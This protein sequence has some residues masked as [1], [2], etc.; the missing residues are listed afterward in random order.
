LV[1]FLVGV[2]LAAGFLAVV[3]YGPLRGT[4]IQ[5]YLIHP[6]ECAELIMFGIA[7][8]ALGA[9]LAGSWAER[10]ASRTAVLPTW[11]GRAVP[12]SEASK[13]L[14]GLAQLPRRLQNTWMVKRA[15]A[16]LEFLCSRGSANELDD[17]LRTLADNDAT[18]LES[19]YSLIRLIT[20]AVPILGFLGTVLG[21]TTAISGVT[22]E[23]LENNISNVT[24]GLSEA[25]D[26]TA[27]A[28]GLTMVAMFI[29]FVVERVEQGIL[30]AVDRFADR[31]LAHRFERSG[32]E[33]GEFVEVVRRNSDVLVGAMEQLVQ[34][35]TTLWSAALEAAEKRRL[36]VEQRQ[37][38]R[39]TAGLEVALK[40]T[41]DAHAQRLAAWE[42]Q[43]ADQGGKLL[44]Q[45]TALAGAVRDMGHEQQ[46]TLGQISQG[47]A[48]QME[49]LGELQNGEKHLRRLQDTLNQN[50][51]ALAG[52]GTFEQAL[53]SLTAAIHLL[54]A[55]A[56]A[57]PATTSNRLGTRPG[58]AA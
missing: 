38:D 10:R 37:Q 41:L 27:L 14:A 13:Y 36:E 15:T 8:A 28:L 3:H 32:A 11:D 20:W 47:L 16:V 30:D 26:T 23:K 39:L 2:P 44:E 51:T 55:R 40:R 31:E 5:H 19:S 35:Q 18:V 57:T 6:A 46:A 1:G 45:L 29:S 9:K 22:P 43:T 34:R 17:Q 53:H 7:L 56:G 48:D 54:T 50:L 42:N 49:A 12:V 24:D 58:A 4:Q 25:F 21:I 33:G 52:A